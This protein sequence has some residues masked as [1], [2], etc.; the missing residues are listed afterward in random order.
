MSK[1]IVK[2]IIPIVFMIICSIKVSRVAAQVAPCGLAQIVKLDTP[3]TITIDGNIDAAWANV[4]SN[5]I[6]NVTVGTLQSGFGANWKAMWDSVYLYVLVQVNDVLIRPYPGSDSAFKYDAVE[7][8]VSG[9]NNQGTSYGAHDFQYLFDFGTGTNHTAAIFTG[10]GNGGSGSTVTTGISYAI[11]SLSGGY[12]MEI[13]IPWSN[14]GISP[15]LN[16]NIGFD[17]AIDDDDNNSGARDAQVEWNA[18]S[19]QAFNNP[20]LFGTTPLVDCDTSDFSQILGTPQQV[21]TS[22]YTAYDSMHYLSFDVQYDYT[23]DTAIGSTPL[24]S[25]VLQG[26]YTMAGRKSLYNIGNI[27]FMQND[28]F[29]ISV[30]NDQRFILVANPRRINAGANLPLR[31]MMDSI[32]QAYNT[33][34][35]VSDTILNNGALGAINFIKAD[36]LAQFDK[37]CI[38]YYNLNRPYLRSI[39]YVFK[40]PED[41]IL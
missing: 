10:P 40:D 35:T 21:L 36:S 32:V 6:S 30:Y 5:N 13:K 1:K 26:S 29:F 2:N 39:S 8:F 17:V 34:Y 27:Q 7:V 4:Q 9:N 22:I 28:S 31:G 33:H 25:T 12:N 11:D 24:V 19:T 16:N 37:F 23:E 41:K 38:T 20:S 3:A 18:T 15:I 14:I